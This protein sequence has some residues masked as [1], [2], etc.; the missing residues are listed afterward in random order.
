MNNVILNKTYYQEVQV[1]PRTTAQQIN[2]PIINYLDDKYMIGIETFS[3]TFTPKAVSG[4]PL[5]NNN[6]LYSSYLTLVVGDVNW[7]WNIP[8]VKLITVNNYSFS[9]VASSPFA[10]EFEYLRIE[11]SKSYIFIADVSTISTTQTESFAFNIMYDDAMSDEKKHKETKLLDH[12]KQQ[13]LK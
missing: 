10:I 8:L 13:L 4:A 7:I 2:F 9:G 12:K 11:W 6:L 1:Q 5:A 3:V